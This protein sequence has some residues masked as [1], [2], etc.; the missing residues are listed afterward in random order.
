MNKAIQF[1]SRPK[2]AWRGLIALIESIAAQPQ[3]LHRWELGG[4]NH[5]EVHIEASTE[6]S[7]WRVIQQDPG[8]NLSLNLPL[9]DTLDQF[10]AC[11][12]DWFENSSRRLHKIHPGLASIFRLEQIELAHFKD[13]M[14]AFA[15]LGQQS[16]R[17][18]NPIT[19]GPAPEASF[20]GNY[21]ALMGR[22][23]SAP[24]WLA[25]SQSIGPVLYRGEAPD[26][27]RRGSDQH[28]EWMA[29]ASE[30]PEQQPFFLELQGSRLLGVLLSKGSTSTFEDWVGPQ[31]PHQL[32]SPA[33]LEERLRVF[34]DESFQF[35]DDTQ[36]CY[37]EFC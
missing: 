3:G 14:Q 30:S 23:F 26:L 36:L 10:F 33:I 35:E 37:G 24:P 16:L 21:R 17:L 12:L 18:N 7:T 22:A 29:R 11:F 19:D 13:G 31:G 4:L 15:G 28:V 34:G 25:S 8:A 2:D 9:G 6:K 20:E 1:Q 27:N 5:W 32:W